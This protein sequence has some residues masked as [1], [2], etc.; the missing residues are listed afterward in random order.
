LGLLC[1]RELRRVASLLIFTDSL[2]MGSLY[3][4]DNTPA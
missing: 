3:C 2:V 1:P 4:E